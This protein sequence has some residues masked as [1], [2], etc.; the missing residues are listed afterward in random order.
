[1]KIIFTPFPVN[2]P[3]SFRRE[4]NFN[5]FGHFVRLGFYFGIEAVQDFAVKSLSCVLTKTYRRQRRGGPER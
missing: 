5:G 4:H 1:V 3:A 2:E